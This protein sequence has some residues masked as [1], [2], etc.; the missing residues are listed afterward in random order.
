MLSIL[1]VRLTIKVKMGIPESLKV[2][3][4]P[5]KKTGSSHLKLDLFFKLSYLSSNFAL[6]LGY[7]NPA[8]NNLAL[9]FK[10]TNIIYT[11]LLLEIVQNS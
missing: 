2:G 3:W 9:L 1:C 7:L 6:T 10:K 11:K 4:Y 5:P 8:S